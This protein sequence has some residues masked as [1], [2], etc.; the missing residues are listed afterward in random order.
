MIDQEQIHKLISA[1]LTRVLLV[2]ETALPAS[3][4]QAYRIFVLDEF[5]NNGLRKELDKIF[6]NTM[7][8]QGTGR[9]NI[10]QRKGCIMSE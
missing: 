6:S 3:Q 8:R 1:K 9:N 10:T 2:A 4:F 7:D 5:G